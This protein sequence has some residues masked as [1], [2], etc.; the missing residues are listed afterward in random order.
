M[1]PTAKQIERIG[2]M[3]AFDGEYMERYGAICGMD[4]AGRGPLAGPV[5]AACVI[6]PMD[7]DLIYTIN[8]S[9]K[10]S[11]KRRVESSGLIKEKAIAYGIAFADVEEIERIN[12]LEATRLAMQRA[13]AAMGKD[14]YLL[15]DAVQPNSLGLRGEGIIKGDTLSYHI[16]A[17]SILAKVE[18]DQLMASYG[19]KYPLYG[20]DQ[21]KGYC[22]K[23]HTDAIKAYGPIS[24]IHRMSFLTRILHG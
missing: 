15:C 8:D 19:E 13:Y 17:A 21:H 18:R 9:K 14:A 10:L 4:E 20:F 6:M 11:E 23:A 5:C 1:K 3:T 22:T 2:L 7:D 16:A 24:G 12:I